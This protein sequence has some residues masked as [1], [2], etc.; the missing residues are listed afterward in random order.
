[1]GA[2]ELYENIV[3]LC[4]DGNPFVIATVVEAVGSTP[5]KIGSKM[6]ILPDGSTMDTI[7]GGKVEHQIIQDALDCL[8]QGTSRTVAYELRPVGD[9]ALGMLCGGETSVFLDV[10]TLGKTLI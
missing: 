6:L 1:M 7:G 3:A 8:R 2:T 4:Q 10:H 9:H 5:R